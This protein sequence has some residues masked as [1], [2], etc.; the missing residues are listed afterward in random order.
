MPIYYITLHI[1]SIRIT[2]DISSLD[3]LLPK[4]RRLKGAV[5]GGEEGRYLRIEGRYQEWAGN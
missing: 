2:D 3:P 5:E 1:N 4:S